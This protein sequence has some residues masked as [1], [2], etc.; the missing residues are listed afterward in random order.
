[1]STFATDPGDVMRVRVTL[2]IEV[3]PVAWS[4]LFG[5]GNETKAKI[6]TDV[7]NYAR[8]EMATCSA[9]EELAII[10]VRDATT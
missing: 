3:D 2:T 9:A 1:M 7:R 6:R 4:E 8:Q 5:S 10:D